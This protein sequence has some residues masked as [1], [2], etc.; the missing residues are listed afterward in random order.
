[1]K[2]K[3]RFIALF[4]FIS[5][6]LAVYVGYAH[7]KNFGF[8]Y[9]IL[10]DDMTMS[11]SKGQTAHSLLSVLQN[12]TQFDSI[13]VAKLWLKLNP[14]Y[15]QIKKGYYSFEKGESLEDI[16]TKI[17]KGLVAQFSV[18][19][20]E[21][22][23]LTQWLETLAS[24]EH[25]VNDIA[26]VDNLYDTIVVDENS[27]CANKYRSL[28]GCLLANTYFFERET[29]ASDVI[30][31]SFV[32]MK[33]LLNDAW[34]KRFL[35][36][37]YQNPYELLIMASIIEKETAVPSERGIIAGVFDNRLGKNMRLQTD[38]TVIYGIKD[39]DGNITRKHLREKT[40]YNTYV[41][42]G[43][44]I[45][46][47]AM[48]GPDSIYAAAQPELT[49]AIYFVAKG[50]GTHHFSETLAE[51]NAAVRKYQLNKGK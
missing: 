40:P 3:K 20:I 28:E 14:Q 31:R 8:Q 50:D 19:L 29:K 38:P 25:L 12:E 10:K 18:T 49:E 51:H 30:K 7:V 17:S 41:I 13:L 16:F 37:H 39:F 33:E 24:N 9:Q 27:F 22:L 2:I 47:I 23:T 48:A 36:T 43:L 1:M 11:I 34:T 5:S 45:T 6:V 46:P 15:S 32:E 35:D 21:G 4:L 44:P 26:D 42:R